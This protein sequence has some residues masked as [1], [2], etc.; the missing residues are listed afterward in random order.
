MAD[1]DGAAGQPA[2]RRELS[3]FSLTAIL[4]SAIIGSGIFFLPAPMLDQAGGVWPVMLA[5]VVG[6]L[7]ALSGGLLFAE[8]GAAFPKEGGQYAFL[9]DALGK[10]WAFLFAW[11]GFAVVQ[12][13]TI[14]AVA[15]AFAGTIDYAVGL[16]GSTPCLGAID[17]DGCNGLELPKWGVGFVAVAAVLALTLLNQWGV[18]RAA[19]LNDAASITKTVGLVAIAAA[20]FLLGDG[21]G[22]YREPGRQLGAITVSGFSLALANALFAYDG[23]AQT[24]F[25]A[26][27]AKDPRRSVP[28][29]IVLGTLLVAAVY[30]AATFAYFH[31]LGA[32]D[33]SQAARD[34][35]VPIAAEA[36][37]AVVGSVAGAFVVLAVLVSTFGTVNTYILTSPRIYHPIAREGEFPRAF[38][39]LNRHGVPHFGLW[40][41]ALWAGILTMTGGYVALANLVVFGLYV[42]Y[43]ATVVAYFVLR[44]RQREAFAG[45]SFRMP[46]GPLPA[47][48]FAAAAVWVLG[49]YVEA[50][51]DL[52]A[53][54]RIGAFL[55]S[56][57]S[58][59]VLLIGS[60]VVLYA[61]QRRRPARG[62]A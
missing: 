41:G 4:V 33:V 1:P 61:L 62:A 22:G 39:R 59:G 15:V 34:G 52:L 25:V 21:A 26:A 50:D 54:G 44:H 35:A 2:L 31:V 36:M 29:A 46:L 18:R 3:T 17:A 23:F 30:L 60:G 7:V 53:A 49:T 9:R 8:L 37:D 58:L 32:D 27:E 43:L 55:A 40:Y 6:G 19:L 51:L 5:W 47:V 12:T 28:R 13:G 38:G 56:T 14:A 11:S 57:T 42:F 16:P 48:L 45:A 20:A 10:G 24:T